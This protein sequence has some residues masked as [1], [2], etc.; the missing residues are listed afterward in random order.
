MEEAYLSSGDLARATGNTV[1]TVRFY[2]EQGLLK[3]AVVSG[4]GHRRYTAQDLERLRLILDLRELGL[5]LFDIR[6]FLELRAGCSS[7]AEFAVR[8]RDVLLRHL[9]R[10]EARLEQ[11]RRVKRELRRA[12]A[13]G[14]AE[15]VGPADPLADEALGRS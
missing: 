5:S 13:K 14:S 6:A 3:P 9:D 1:R 2:E 11:L 7:A 15:E 10:A 8:A 4:G 12:L